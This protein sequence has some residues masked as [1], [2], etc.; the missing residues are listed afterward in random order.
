MHQASGIARSAEE[1]FAGVDI[2]QRRDLNAYSISSGPNTAFTRLRV[3]EDNAG[4]NRADNHQGLLVHLHERPRRTTSGNSQLFC[5]HDLPQQAGRF[6]I[7]AARNNA[8]HSSPSSFRIC[9]DAF[10]ARF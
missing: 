9:V 1:F 7:H 3:P 6:E 5:R 10:D 4:G 8:V 2:L